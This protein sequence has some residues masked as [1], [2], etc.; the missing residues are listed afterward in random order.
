[1]CWESFGNSR[2]IEREKKKKNIKK[3]WN[4]KEHAFYSIIEAKRWMLETVHDLIH[5]CGML[6]NSVTHIQLF[7]HSEKQKQMP[8][9]NSFHKT[10]NIQKKNHKH[11]QNT[12]KIN[13]TEPHAV[14]WTLITFLLFWWTFTEIWICNNFLWLQLILRRYNNFRWSFWSTR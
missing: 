3:E 14:K 13:T 7:F 4:R 1:M 6:E 9:K 2:F 11:T 8:K 5:E 12:L 10:A